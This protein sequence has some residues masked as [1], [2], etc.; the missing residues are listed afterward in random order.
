MYWPQALHFCRSIHLAIPT[1][2]S[3][4]DDFDLHN[5][6]SVSTTPQLTPHSTLSTPTTPQ[7]DYA[8][9]HFYSIQGSFVDDYA[10]YDPD[11]PSAY[12]II[13]RLYKRLP[14]PTR[15][16]DPVDQYWETWSP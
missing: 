16:F 1:L 15:S 7:P 6:E 9:T 4:Y 8:I 3:H 5:L 11:P 13:Q 2:G 10:I 14:S 12:D